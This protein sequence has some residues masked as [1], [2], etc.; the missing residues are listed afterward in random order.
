MKQCRHKESTPSVCSLDRK[1]NSAKQGSLEMIETPT[2]A[3]IKNEN[4]S[5]P[6]LKPTITTELQRC[7]EIRQCSKCVRTCQCE[8]DPSSISPTPVSMEMKE[9]PIKRSG[10]LDAVMCSITNDLD[11][12]LNRT[13]DTKSD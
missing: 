7:C 13:I 4:I 8:D 1:R 12:L 6:N 3:I 5:L 2:N 11:Y 9:S 10:N